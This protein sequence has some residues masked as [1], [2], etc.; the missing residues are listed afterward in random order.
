MLFAIALAAS[1]TIGLRAYGQL[2]QPD[3]ALVWKAS[4]LRSIPTEADSAQKSAPL[5][6]GSI[7]IADRTFL[8]WTHL[9]FGGGQSGWVRTE[10]VVKLYR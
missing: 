3:V 1:A 9:A 4:L 10:D 7:A 6:A 2:A 5:S 8:G